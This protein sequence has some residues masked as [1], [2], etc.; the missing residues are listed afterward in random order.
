M[1][2]C[3]TGPADVERAQDAILFG[4]RRTRAVMTLRSRGLGVSLHLSSTSSVKF[5]KRQCERVANASTVSGKAALRQA[6]V[7]ISAVGRGPSAAAFDGLSL[8]NP[9]ATSIS[10]SSLSKSARGDQR[11]APRT[12]TSLPPC[13]NW[14]AT[15][16]LQ[17]KRRGTLAQKTAGLSEGKTHDD[18]LEDVASCQL[19]RFR[20]RQSHRKQGQDRRSPDWLP[21]V[22]TRACV[23]MCARRA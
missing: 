20:A 3:I 14:I 4:R 2:Q 7:P 21:P 15:A 5:F 11:L 22:G 16:L 10:S 18:Q 12:G 1:P 17:R 8:E 9:A 19:D 23:R 6:E 13:R